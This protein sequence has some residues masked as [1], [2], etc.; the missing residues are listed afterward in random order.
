MA[1][2]Y[3]FIKIL[4]SENDSEENMAAISNKQYFKKNYKYEPKD[5]CQEHTSTLGLINDAHLG[6]EQALMLN[7]VE[8]K[9]RIE[10]SKDQI[11]Q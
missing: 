7:D 11:K 6:D 3:K 4:P 5:F 10:N 1:K 9:N 8:I 2:F